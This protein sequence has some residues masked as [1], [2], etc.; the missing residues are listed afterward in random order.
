MLIAEGPGRNEDRVGRPF[1]GLAGQE[2]DETYFRLAGLERDDFF[3]TNCVQCR[4][5]RNGV[6]IKPG[7]QLAQT[8][9]TNHLPEEI[10]AVQPEVVVLAGATACSLAGRIDLELEHGFPRRGEIFGYECTI[11]PMYHPAAGMHETRYMTPLLEDWDRLGLWLKGKWQPPAPVSK[12]KQYK[13]ITSSKQF[14]NIEFGKYDYMPV[15]TES[16]EG[17]PYSLQFSPRPGFGYMILAEN[18]SL[19]EDFDA[20]MVFEN[21]AQYVLH[22]ATYDLDELDKMGVYV[23]SFRDTMQ[24]LYHLGNLPQ[25]LKAAVYRIFG[26]R[27]TS[28]DEVVTPHSKHKL[29]GWLAEA[30][31]VASDVLSSTELHP[32]GPDCPTCGK[33]HRLDVSKRKPHESEATLRRIMGKMIEEGS[34]YDAWQAPKYEK[35]EY[36]ARLIGRSWLEELEQAVGARMPR[37]SIVH[38]PMDRQIQY[39][40]GDADF[41]GRLATW[42]EGERKRIVQ[43]EW[44]VAA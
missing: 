6:D 14:D 7:D 10:W 34:E 17:R 35:G 11:V 32:I 37:K 43:N 27:M 18:K 1:V 5:E 41:T 19:I 9:G 13:L 39:A 26:Y 31:A 40:V 12:I 16:D 44:K 23:K 4:C 25:G 33:K 20:C 8:C 15:D 42:L 28:Y 21:N 30:L 2:Q 38:A 29:E 36:K 24:E 3:L 22:N